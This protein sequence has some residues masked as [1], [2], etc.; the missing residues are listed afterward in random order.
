MKKILSPLNYKYLRQQLS[1]DQLKFSTTAELK[2]LA[3]FLGQER[4]L[5]AVR[6][7]IGIQSQGYNLY[8]MGPSGIGKRSLIRRFLDA[9]K[10]KYVTPCDWC[11]IHN[12]D[13]PEKPIALKL[14]PGMGLVLQKDMKL[15]IDEI[16][17]DIIA[18]FEGYEYI[19]EMKKIADV[20]NKKREKVSKKI[21]N[22]KI[23][24]LYKQQH[25]KE[26]E[27]Q[28]K[29][30]LTV[31]KPLIHKLKKK[32]KKLSDVLKYLTDVQND[33]VTHVHDVIKQDEDTDVL[34]FAVESPVLLRY[35]VN[36]IVDNG[37]QKNAPIIFEDNPSYSNL[38]CRVE[39]TT[40]FGTLVTNF[41]YIKSGSLHK[42]NGGFLII[43]SRKLKKD[44]RAW[45]S[46]KRALYA[47]EIII[48]PVENLS[49]SVKPVS[50][51]PMPIPLNVKVILLGDRAT[52]YHLSNNDPDFNELFKVAVDFDEHIERNHKNIDLYSRLIATFSKR[53]KLRPLL[54]NAVAE[55]I[56]HSTRIAEDTEKLSTHIRVINDLI[57]EADYWA[58]IDK[59]KKI[60][61]NHVKQAIHAQI[62]RQD[63]TREVY[64][65]AINRNFLLINT[66]D[67]LIGQLNCLSVVK[68]GNF[69]FGHP[70][71]VTAKVSVG[72]GKV[73]DIQREIDMAGPIHTKAGLTI[74][75]YLS[76]RY[77]RDFLFSLAASISFEQIYGMMEGDSASVVEL[78]ALLSALA[79]VPLNQA[80]AVTG[81][82]DQYGK[83]Q[84]IGGVN[85]KIEGYFDVC[86]LKGLNGKQ[87]VIIPAMNVKNL[88][89]R[90]DIVKACKDGFFAIYTMETV[91]QA[92]SLLTGLSA[93]ERDKSG[94]F[95][96]DSV[97]FKVEKR[98]REFYQ[99]RKRIKKID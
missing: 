68:V 73:I 49:G 56:D 5:S 14:P 50:L 57:L 35:Q 36:V 75:N 20:F 46:L 53:E 74:E 37:N 77:S 96:K 87:G 33:I 76:S 23:P 38:I 7:G 47:K 31:V 3:Q 81:S 83:V 79:E 66:H 71:R 65:E 6:F 90:E 98:L 85:E 12:F 86:K 28:L 45:E 88:M 99:G 4:A 41:S 16:A 82:I 8:A 59:K 25:K 26:Q 27:L 60:E 52:Y 94:K 39:H 58:S 78:C 30:T 42:A 97:N 19:T 43:E 1:A 9:E 95:P 69:S 93:G 64:Y 54:A 17:S 61:I 48:D 34:S 22:D 91:D 11:Y 40:Q 63:R 32:Y 24:Y 13:T 84:V 51:E 70:T 62:Y 89:L 2:P 15:F 18:V 44:P 80:L 92:L 21:N 72:K 29:L 10:H 67:K 55:I